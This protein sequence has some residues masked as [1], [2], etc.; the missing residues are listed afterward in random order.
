VPQAFVCWNKSIHEGC[1]K[2][3]FI[4]YTLPSLNVE[5]CSHE[6]PCQ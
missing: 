1:H 2:R 6:I 5:P 4:I 3:I